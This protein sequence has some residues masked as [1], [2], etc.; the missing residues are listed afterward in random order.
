MPFL[1]LTPAIFSLLVTCAH[2]FRGGAGLLVLV[3][4]PLPWLLLLRRGWVARFFQVFLLL[5]TLEWIRT[6][7]VLALERHKAGA[8]WLR[9][10][11]IL[12]AVATFNFF[13]M[14]LFETRTLQRIYPRH[15][16]W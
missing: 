1:L 15:S 16:S 6:G 3:V 13:A 10:A 14:A 2:L 8:P 12:G 4:L 7:V 9:M 11:L 5:A